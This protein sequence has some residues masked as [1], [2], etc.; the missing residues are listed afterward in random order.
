MGNFAVNVDLNAK[1]RVKVWAFKIR[2]PKAKITCKL[3]VPALVRPTH[4]RS[5]P[6]IAKSGS[7]FGFSFGFDLVVGF[8]F[9]RGD[10]PGGG[11]C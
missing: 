5:S 7:N 9:G 8:G 1:L 10:A 2:G 6:R 4:R 11:I 3:S